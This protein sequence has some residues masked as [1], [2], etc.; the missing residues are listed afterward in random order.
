MAISE[1]E[2]IISV[3]DLGIRLTWEEFL[4]L[5]ARGETLPSGNLSLLSPE[6]VDEVGGVL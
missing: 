6:E 3:P 5:A 1:R 4:E 2:I